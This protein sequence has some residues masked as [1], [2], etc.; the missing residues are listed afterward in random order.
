MRH[1]LSKPVLLVLVFAA[2]AALAQE[3]PPNQRVFESPDAAANA[4]VAACEANDTKELIAIFGPLFAAET[5][6]VDESEQ[7]A[8]RAKIAELAKQIQ[9][10]EERSDSQRVLLLGRELWPLPMPIVP[11]GPGWRFD[12]AAG[13][14]ELLRRRVGRNELTAID[15]CHEFVKAQREYARADRDGDGTVEFAGKILS[16]PGTRDGLYWEVAPGSGE[17]LSPFGPH[18]AA[19]DA[20]VRAGETN[21]FMGYRFR[22]LTSQGKHAPGGKSSYMRGDDMTHGFALI[23]WPMD[24][25]H[26]GVMTFMVNHL[27]A[28]YEKDLGPK[29]APAAAR[30]RRFDPD[31]SWKF[32]TQSE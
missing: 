24:Y 17:A 19:A 6:R 4:F 5:G 21:G 27:G 16:T 31:P 8:N 30:I 32:V 1:N 9:R 13:F 26:S 10:L 14:D 20:S 29:T 2:C 28:V 12:T 15:V 23:A 22:V 18:L 7:R 11:A 3:Q 25:G